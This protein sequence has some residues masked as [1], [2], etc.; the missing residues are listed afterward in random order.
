M[1]VTLIWRRAGTPKEITAEDHAFSELSRVAGY[2]R[3][4]LVQSE[5]R[6]PSVLWFVLLVGARCTIASTCVR[7]VN[8]P[9]HIIQ[10]G[11]FALLTS[12][13]RW[14]RLPTSTGPYKDQCM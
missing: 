9:L 2:R 7:R 12:R 5:E 6:L 13:W 3:I 8:G 4:R 1:W 10:V 14:W 11:A